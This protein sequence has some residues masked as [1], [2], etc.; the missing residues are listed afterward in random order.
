[1][2][3]S[4]EEGTEMQKFDLSLKIDHHA[5]NEEADQKI[6]HDKEEMEDNKEDEDQ[7]AHD[8]EIEEEEE[9]DDDRSMVDISVQESTKTREVCTY[10]S[11]F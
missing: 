2:D 9:D 3:R 11:H 7:A 10:F 5:K 6:V 8:D 4:E 1:M